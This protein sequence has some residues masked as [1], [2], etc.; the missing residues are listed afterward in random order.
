[1]KTS[2]RDDAIAQ[3][4]QLLAVMKIAC[5][6]LSLAVMVL[7]GLCFYAF[8]SKEVVYQPAMSGAYTLSERHFS[9]SYLKAM[10]SDFMQLRLT[11]NPQT[12]TPRYQQLMSMVSPSQASQVRQALNQ[13]IKAVQQRK[14]TSVFYEDRVQVD[15]SHDEAKVSGSLQRLDDGVLLPSIPKTY[16]LQFHYVAGTLELVS[17]TDQHNQQDK[18]NNQEKENPHG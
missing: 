3:T 13:E 5:L 8:F 14:M 9:P 12:I 15:V 11:W 1:M 16:V 7:S 4:K 2:V 17:I 10:A 18:A 6:A